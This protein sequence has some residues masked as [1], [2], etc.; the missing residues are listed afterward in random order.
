MSCLPAAASALP[1]HTAETVTMAA[2]AGCHWEYAQEQL[3]HIRDTGGSWSGAEELACYG[4]AW[5]DDDS[6]LQGD[7]FVDTCYRTSCDR[8]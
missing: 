3:R 4:K 6:R 8:H 2:P 7:Q 5:E 1:G